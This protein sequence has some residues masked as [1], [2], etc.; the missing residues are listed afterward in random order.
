MMTINLGII[1]LTSSMV[2]G[3]KTKIYIICSSQYRDVRKARARA[4]AR[5]ALTPN[6]SGPAG[7]ENPGL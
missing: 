6:S 4:R 5:R 2:G 3:K 1:C 7:P